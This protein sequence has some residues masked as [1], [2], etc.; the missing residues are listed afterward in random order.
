LTFYK[1]YDILL[2]QNFYDDRERS[3]ISFMK[4]YMRVAVN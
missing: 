4:V 1:F 3:S 2:I